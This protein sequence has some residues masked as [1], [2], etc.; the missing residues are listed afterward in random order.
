MHCALHG[1]AAVSVISGLAMAY[2]SMDGWLHARMD[3]RRM[4]EDHDHDYHDD[5]DHD[6]HH[7]DHDDHV[8]VHACVCMD[9][10]MHMHK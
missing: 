2:T 9:G 6:D 7:D 8:D 4:I 10:S 3:G 5:H 1:A